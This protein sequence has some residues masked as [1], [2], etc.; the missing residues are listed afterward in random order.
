L[1]TGVFVVIAIDNGSVNGFCAVLHDDRF[2]MP[3][4]GLGLLTNDSYIENPQSMSNVTGPDNAIHETV[5]RKR[6]T[7]LEERSLTT[8]AL[9]PIWVVSPWP[10]LAGNVLQLTLPIVFVPPYK[11][12]VDWHCCLAVW[13][14]RIWSVH[15]F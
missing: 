3:S 1:S 9:A 13:R 7:H 8:C 10:W 2:C 12:I 14:N 5:V 15:V 4:H 11:W 6:V